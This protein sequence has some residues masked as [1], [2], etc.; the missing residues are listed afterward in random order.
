[1]KH[2]NVFD[3][4]VVYTNGIAKSPANRSSKI[5]CPFPNSRANYNT[6]YAYFLET[7]KRAGLTAALCTSNDIIDAGTA[8]R[9]WLYEHKVWK[10]VNGPCSSRL[11]FDKFS[12]INQKKKQERQLLFSSDLIKPFN[13][14]HLSFLFF[15]KLETYHRLGDFAIPTV[16]IGGTSRQAVRESIRL[17]R[18]L[19]GQGLSLND[20]TRSIVVKDRFGAGG[21]N[22]SKVTKNYQQEIYSLVQAKKSLSYIL[23]PFM[24]FNKGYSYQNHTAAT[25]LRLI[26]QN[27]QI[28]QT[29]IRM[30]KAG[31]FRCNEHQGATLLY[32]N[33]KD[34]PSKVIKFADKIISKLNQNNSL[35]A[36]DFIISD[37][38]NVYFLE[39]NIGPGLDW[40]LK[41][42]KNEQMSKKLIRAIVKE[43]AFRTAATR[44]DRLQ[45]DKIRPHIAPLPSSPLYASVNA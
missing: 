33:I 45:E 1:M 40:N 5:S 29:Y 12:P 16:A 21:N 15:D 2:T 27:G 39:G 44:L 9:Y 8:S 37:T 7:C 34:I 18:R 43:L 23:Q 11:I 41:L 3:V 30:A 17:L 28:I 25:D 24:K 22:I 35:F 4:L 32:V 13:D 26:Y 31:D 19:T 20:F 6:A 14:P 42:K 38:G 36:L 10:K